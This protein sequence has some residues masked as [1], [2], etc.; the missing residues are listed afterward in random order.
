MKYSGINFY[1]QSGISFSISYMNYD[2]FYSTNFD[3]LSQNVR[4]KITIESGKIKD[5]SDNFIYFVDPKN[6]FFNLSGNL[7]K[8]NFNLSIDNNIIYNTT[9]DY[10]FCSGINLSWNGSLNFEKDLDI[11]INGDRPLYNIIYKQADYYKNPLNLKISGDQNNSFPFVVHDI[12]INP[13]SNAT[14]YFVFSG[15]Q[16]KNIQIDPQSY[17]DLTILQSEPYSSYYLPL[18]L[19]TNFGTINQTLSI[20]RFSNPLESGVLSVVGNVVV[21]SLDTLNIS[22]LYSNWNIILDLYSTYSKTSGFFVTL[23]GL[24]NNNRFLNGYQDSF[25]G[26]WFIKPN[27]ANTTAWFNFDL[28]VK[29]NLILS[30]NTNNNQN[31]Y[32]NTSNGYITNSEFGGRIFQQSGIQEYHKKYWTIT[33]ITV[34]LYKSGVPTGLSGIVPTGISG[35]SGAVMPPNIILGNNASQWKSGIIRNNPSGSLYLYLYEGNGFT[36]S[37]TGFNKIYESG[38]NFNNLTG[39]YLS[40]EYFTFN[41]P[42]IEFNY[43]KQYIVL[44]SGSASGYFSGTMTGITGDGLTGQLPVYYKDNIYLSNGNSLYNENNNLIS[45]GIFGNIESGFNI[46]SDR[47]ITLQINGDELHDKNQ[48]TGYI[49]TVPFLNYQ[50]YN[51]MISKQIEFN[52]SFEFLGQA[53]YIIS[54]TNGATYSGL[55]FTDEDIYRQLRA[56]Y[57]ITEQKY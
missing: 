23:S 20:L 44:F 13:T 24:Q 41:V 43:N 17:V 52:N 18:V 14:N 42:E 47:N 2:N 34:N 27:T 6:K 35:L 29:N 12:N 56:N 15:N 40:G 57:T 38:R 37:L 10:G 25:T 21:G 53:M 55:L 51:L 31:I 46:Y 1:P 3:F 22:D 33:G 32:S 30:S 8:N 16:N 11:K 5:K 9:G 50:S 4:E 39:K 26:S 19:N 45:S 48:I 54:G 49:K 36:G 28:P 7:S